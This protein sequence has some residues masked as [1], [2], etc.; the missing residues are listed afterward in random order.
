MGVGQTHAG[1]RAK[2][3]RTK[4]PYLYPDVSPDRWEEQ[5]NCKGK[6]FELF[7]YQDTDSPLTDGMNYRTRME[8]NKVNYELASEICIECPVMLECGESA[9]A[10]EKHWTVRGGLMPGRFEYESKRYDNNGRPRSKGDDRICQRGHVVKGGGRCPVCK[11]ATNERAR[12]RKAAE[13]GVES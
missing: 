3:N 9:S 10:Q 5:A 7:E 1:L 8:F 4:N 11:K 12:A 2:K 13:R 6:A